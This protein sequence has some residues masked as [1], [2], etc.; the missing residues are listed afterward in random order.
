MRHDSL[1]PGVQHQNGK[2]VATQSVQLRLNGL[3]EALGRGA[4]V[5]GADNPTAGPLD[6]ATGVAVGG[7]RFETKPIAAI[8][9]HVEMDEQALIGQGVNPGLRLAVAGAVMISLDV[10]DRHAG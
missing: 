8:T 10:D 2:G 3:E 6:E 9:L 4:K 5:A 1:E 7:D